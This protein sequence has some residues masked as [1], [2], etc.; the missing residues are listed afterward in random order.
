L[1]NYLYGEGQGFTPDGDDGIIGYETVFFYPQS[2]E[3]LEITQENSKPLLALIGDL[4]KEDDFWSAALEIIAEILERHSCK[5]S[6]N[7]EDDGWI[8]SNCGCFSTKTKKPS[9][10]TLSEK[11]RQGCF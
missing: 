9:R 2:Q 6:W 10:L 8:C 3:C 7:A 5:H 11:L 4:E 1:S